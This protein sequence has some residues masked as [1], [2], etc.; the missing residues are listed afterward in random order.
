MTREEA[1]KLLQATRLML[2]DGAN[3]PISD[4]YYALV[5]AIEALEQTDPSDSE[6]PNN[7]DTCI[8]NKLEW[9]SEVCDGCSKDHSNYEPKLQGKHADMVIIDEPQTE[10]KKW[11]TP[12]KFEHK[13][14][15]TTCVSVPAC[16]L[17]I[18]DEPQTE[19]V[20][21]KY[22]C[23]NCAE[24]GSYKCSKCDGEMYYKYD[25]DEPQ[26]EE[27]CETCR[28]KDECEGATYEY[29]NAEW[30]C[31]AYAPIDEPQTDCPWR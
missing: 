23:I 9:Y 17:E 30:W 14:F 18:E 5:M 19:L 20:R 27:H 26:T 21:V 31:L 8:H 6:K 10:Y 13:G 12:P 11:E 29:K 2:M 7:C 25:K 16:L 4:L 28:H 1:V 24:N 22:H 15:T 3:Q